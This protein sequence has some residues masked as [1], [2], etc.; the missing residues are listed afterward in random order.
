MCR[1]VK[2]A[3]AKIVSAC[4][5]SSSPTD[6]QPVIEAIVENSARVCGAT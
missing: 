3:K 4:S 1:D 6:L 5:S 2:T